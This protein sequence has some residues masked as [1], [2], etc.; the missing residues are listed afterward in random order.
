MLTKIVC[1]NGQPQKKNCS[2]KQSKHGTGE[3]LMKEQN[4]KQAIEEMAKDIDG[5]IEFKILGL[6]DAFI[7]VRVA[8]ERIAERLYNAGY[9]KQ[10]VV[11]AKF[12]REIAEKI[13]D[14]LVK[15]YQVLKETE[16]EPGKFYTYDFE[17]A[18]IAKGKIHALNGVLDIMDELIIK[19]GGDS[20]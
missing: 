9:R 18:S 8:C 7:K 5:V 13:A 17:R 11:V 14:E 2:K 12:Y 19:Y 4:E 10:S 20:Q 3:Q 15:N 1:P 6:N 16:I